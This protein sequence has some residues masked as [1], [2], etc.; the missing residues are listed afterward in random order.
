MA[1]I[2]IILALLLTIAA[3]PVLAAKEN[4]SNSRVK[5]EESEEV[6]DCSKIDQYKNHG[7]YVSCVAHQKAGGKV[8]SEAAKSSIGKKDDDENENDEDDI[9]PSVTPTINPSVTP[10]ISVTPTATPSVTLSPTP[11]PTESGP[12]STISATPTPTVTA[13]A[14]ISEIQAAIETLNKIIDSL[15]HLISL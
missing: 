12:T 4:N 10:T 9:T 13:Q 8:V 3:T 11:T 14:A 6:Q 7:E 2:F 15:K 5:T 1:K